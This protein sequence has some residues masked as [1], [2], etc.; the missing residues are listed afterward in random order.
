[1]PSVR[2]AVLLVVL[3]GGSAHAATQIVRGSTFLVKDP[4]S[5]DP[6][7]RRVSALAKEEDSEAT[8]VGD[9]AA[10]GAT[11]L[12]VANG[13]T[14]TS[15]EFVL[16]PTGWTA[17]DGGFRYRDAHGASGAVKTAQIRKTRRGVFVLR[18]AIVG[19]NGPIAVV[20]PN[21]GEDGG[22]V[23]TIDGGDSYCV[24]FG[25]DAG[26]T[27]TPG[28]NTSR[29][30]RVKRP[31]GAAC[32][33]PSPT[34]TTTIVTT[35]TTESTTTQ[36]TTTTTE[37]TTIPSS[38]TTSTSGSTA[39]TTTATPSST[40][41]TSTA[42]SSTTTTSTPGGSSTTTTTTTS[43]STTSTT[44]E[45][46]TTTSTVAGSSTTT[47]TAVSATTT[48]STSAPGTTST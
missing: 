35:T 47:T 31:L 18:V 41:T 26:G 43:S 29:V 37:T 40:T 44:S 42:G 1:M 27:I 22:V 48:T 11:V 12:I 28:T 30:F 19:R 17:V 23:L 15:Q 33:I 4:A 20:P 32:P 38:S 9:P 14:S 34:T 10:N 2:L 24:G 7:R 46:S 45:S 6:T 8:V 39:T 25:G 13:A 3:A 16:P 36:S 5:T 21:P